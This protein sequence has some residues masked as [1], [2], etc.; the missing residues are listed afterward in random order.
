MRMLQYN[1]DPQQVIK[2]A[3]ES[4]NSFVDPQ[5]ANIDHSTVDSF[6]E[7]WKKFS[8]FSKLDIKTAGDQ[9]FDIAQGMFDN[10]SIVLDAGCGT[11]RWSLYLSDK[12]SFIEA[13]DPSESVLS[14]VNLTRNVNNIR[15]SLASISNI[16]FAD[17]SFDLVICL[18]VLHHI[19]DSKEA[20]RNLVQKVKRGGRCLIYM[21]YDLDNRGVV[22]KSLFG[23]VNLARRIISSMPSF[24]KK[25]IC[26]I[27]ALFVYLPL[28]FLGRS[29]KAL[30]SN[31]LYKRMP[32]SYYADKSFRI[33]R[34]DALDRFGTPLEQ[35]YN[36]QQIRSMME[37]AGLEDI[38]F[39][40]NEP[41]WHTIGRKK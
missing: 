32:L 20:M 11:G 14:A 23:L 7:E 1:Q 25:L 31:D 41:Y 24:A 34:N 28:V 13:I 36:Q 9:Y 19:P 21:Y 10:G 17:D 33:M 16:P 5:E 29:V 27:I 37:D 40:E 12:V 26:E 15:V 22:Y 3:D 35:R 4:I 2:T 30:T 6:G 39:S 8:E 38:R 18:G